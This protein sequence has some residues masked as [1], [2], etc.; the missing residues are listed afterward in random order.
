M[1]FPGNIFYYLRLKKNKRLPLEISDLFKSAI[2]I[3]SSDNVEKYRNELENCFDNINILDKGAGSRIMNSDVRIVSDIVKRSS[4]SE[5]FGVLYQ[6]IIKKFEIN[7]VLELGTSLGV[8]TMYFALSE[9]QPQITSIDACP[10]TINFTKRKFESKGI[11]NVTFI[12][13]TFDNVFN[14]KILAGKKFDL[15]FIDGNHQSKGVLFY[16]DYISKKLASEKCI[17]IIDDINWTADMYNAWK[18]ICKKNA[19]NLTLNLGRMGL[20]FDSFDDLGAGNY[21]INFVKS[22]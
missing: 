21:P 19:T 4:T 3:E 6:K 22:E 18:T 16:Y 1:K 2:K 20:V 7:S 17:Y 11:K 8:G 12:N 5:D 14:N 10:E 9:N 15:I 13:D